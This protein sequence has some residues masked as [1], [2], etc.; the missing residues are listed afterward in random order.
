MLEQAHDH[1]EIVQRVA[2]LDIG[3][4][5]LTCCIRVPD[6]STPGKRLQEVDTYSTMTRSLLALADRLRCLSVT[7]VV[8]EATS[9][10][11]KPVFYL[12]EAAGLEVWL[13]NSHHV[14][15]LP[16][17][18]KTDKLDAVWLAKVAERQMIRPSFVPPPHIRALR[19]LTR[20]RV[21]LV[22][23]CTAEKNRVE[24]LLEDA[25]I[26]LSVVASSIFGVSGRAM[27]AAL[28]TG[29]RNPTR[30]AQLAR[31]RMR[32]K[33]SSLEE[34]FTGHFTDHHAFLLRLMLA[35]IDAWNADIAI[36]D[37]KI[38][39]HITPY[40]D[41]VERLD[42]IPG[43]GPTAAHVII[44]EIGLDMSRFPTAKHLTSWARFAPGVKESAGKKKGKGATG[45][46][47]AYLAR[48]LGEAAVSVGRTETFLGERYRRIARRRGNK[49]AAV[50]VGRSI[51]TIIWHLL[52]DPTARFIDLGTGF[53]DS[54]LDP[55]RE[56]RRH[57][58]RLQA[59]GYSVTV[60]PAN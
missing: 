54:R 9:D 59:L 49:K 39:Q 48:V 31:G 60:E 6:E 57:I 30:L 2:A 50:A 36:V 14:K 46:G 37:E 29:E 42:E 47:N 26:K 55:E 10:Y 34:A 35:R 27:L 25:Q 16:G 19:D 40:R 22:N 41:T 43:I 8:L 12:L 20:Y 3:K 1:E 13:V 28:I 52:S 15:H 38:S 33:L 32:A 58:R 56:K 53:H 45:H 11:W 24:K 21:D 23:A 7:R 17:R 44:A 51:L 4:A 18:P 5:T